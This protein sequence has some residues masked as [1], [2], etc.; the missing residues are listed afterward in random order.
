MTLRGDRLG[1]GSGRV[2]AITATASDLA[3]E[4]GIHRMIT[5]NKRDL[6]DVQT[7]RHVAEAR[8]YKSRHWDRSQPPP[9]VL[10]TFP[11]A[12]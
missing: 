10:L 7:K 5:K 3:D 8:W 6:E 2:D 11:K 1:T 12:D 4:T 9:F